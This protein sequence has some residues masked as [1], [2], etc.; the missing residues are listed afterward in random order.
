MAGL[1]STTAF[2]AATV[3]EYNKAAIDFRQRVEQA[4]RRAPRT[5]TRTPMPTPSPPDV[6]QVEA[7]TW[8][9]VPFQPGYGLTT[10]GRLYF[11]VTLKNRAD[12]PVQVGVSFRSYQ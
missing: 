6:R 4:A 12:F 1:I 5:V 3:D 8:W 7:P 11:G 9:I 2:R 10:E